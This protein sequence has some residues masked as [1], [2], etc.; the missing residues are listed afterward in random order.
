MNALLNSEETTPS[1]AMKLLV[2]QHGAWAVLRALAAVL[3]PKRR[4]VVRLDDLTPH[5]R[6]DMG[7]PPIDSPRKYWELR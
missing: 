5:L 6:R 7:L 2:D 3:M 4:E 1:V